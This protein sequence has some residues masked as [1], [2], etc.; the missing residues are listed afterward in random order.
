MSPARGA[1]GVSTA[2]SV[3]ATFSEPVTNVT[4]ATFLL[5]DSAGRA[6]LATIS[7]P[8]SGNT[9]TLDPSAALLRGTTYTATVVGGATGVRDLAGNPLASTVTWSFTTA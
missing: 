7:P 6:V 3:K 5:E 2:A 4:G 9:W 8:T 1:T